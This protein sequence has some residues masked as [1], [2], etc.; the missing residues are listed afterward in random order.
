[1]VDGGIEPVF[2]YPH[3]RMIMWL[4]AELMR[5]VIFTHSTIILFWGKKGVVKKE[6]G[7]KSFA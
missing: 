6:V 1:M 7:S 2:R 3:G 5:F 4:M